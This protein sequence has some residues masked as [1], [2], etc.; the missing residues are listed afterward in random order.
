MGSGC[1][2]GLHMR[3]GLCVQDMSSQMTAVWIRPPYLGS[4][5]LNAFSALLEARVDSVRCFGA[6][7]EGWIPKRRPILTRCAT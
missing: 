4:T 6:H 3:S 2:F 5:T 7:E 1:R